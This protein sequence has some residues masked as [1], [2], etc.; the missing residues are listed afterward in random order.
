MIVPDNFS[1]AARLWKFCYAREKRAWA[2]A[3]GLHE[4]AGG[5][6]HRRHARWQCLRLRIQA[7]DWRLV[8]HDE[9]GIPA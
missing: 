8:P 3:A 1:A 4:Y 9:R 7:S 5:P 2:M 6:W